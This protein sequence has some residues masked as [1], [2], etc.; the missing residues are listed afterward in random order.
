M[1]AY[2]MAA[3]V[4][5]GLD[6]K[7][8]LLDLRSENARLQLVGRLFRAAT[9]RLEFIEKAQVRARSNGR[10]ASGERRRRRPAS[11]ANASTTRASNCVRR[12]GAARRRPPPAC[13]PRRRAAR[14]H[15]VERVADEDDARLERD[16]L[17]RQPVGVAGAVHPLVARADDAARR[18]PAPARRTGSARRSTVCSRMSA[19][20][21]L[22]QAPGLVQD[23]VG[24]RHLADVVQLGGP[25]RAQRALAQPQAPPDALGQRGDAVDVGAELGV[26][27]DRTARRTSALCRAA[28]C[29]RRPSRRT[30]AGRRAAAPRRARPPRRAA[31]PQ[32]NE[33]P[34]WKP[35]PLG[36]WRS[37][38]QGR[39]ARASPAATVSST[40]NS[41]PPSR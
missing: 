29:G 1:S 32:P 37:P 2:G 4:D 23:R 20:S 34:T 21:S 38:P 12:R 19:H 6:A 33:A 7:Q 25:A 41:S 26:A 30:A 31:P 10:C 36:R 9:K 40:Q 24:D 3:T 27:P 22:V 16:L 14:G 28:E 8:G 18:P 11:A 13:A 39:G 35:S 5:F 15:R 17:A